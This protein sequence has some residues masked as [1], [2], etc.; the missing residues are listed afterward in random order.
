MS[1]IG[2]KRTLK[3]VRSMSALPSIADMLQRDQKAPFEVISPYGLLGSR[4]S[5]GTGR[6]VVGLSRMRRSGFGRELLYLGPD[7]TE[8]TE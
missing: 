5:I 3:H 4:L 2:Q 7:R 8:R 6:T 1:A